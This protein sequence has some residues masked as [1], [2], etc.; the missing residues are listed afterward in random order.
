MFL[1]S[2]LP[3]FFPLGPGQYDIKEEEAQG[4]L[5]TTRQQRF[6][7]IKSETPGPGS[8]EVGPVEIRKYGNK[9]FLCCR[10][11]TKIQ[12]SHVIE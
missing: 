3:V 11:V 2:F 10:G 1:R 12:F 9:A 4:G 7:S 5:M 6:I 8:Y